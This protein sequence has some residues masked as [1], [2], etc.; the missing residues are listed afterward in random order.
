MTKINEVNKNIIKGL[1]KAEVLNRIKDGKVNILPKAPSRTIG[2]IVRANLFTSYNALNAILAIIVFMAGS[3]KNAVFAGVI[4]TNTIIGMFQ[5]IRAKGILERLSVLNEK[6]VDVIREGEINNINV[7]E[8]VLDDIIVLKAG[9]Q[10][11]VDCELLSHNE[12]E[13]DESL[14]TGEPDSILKIENDKLLSGSFVSAGNAYA[15]VI[16]VGENTYA[17]KLAEEA[18]KFKLI[19]SELQISINKIFR[20]IMWLAIPIGSLLI[21]TQL[22]HVKKSWQDAVLGSV[23]GIVGMVPEGLVLLTSATFVVAVIRLSKWDTLI[24]ELPA[25][26]V[27]ARVDVLCLDKTGTITK[28][29]LKVT[30]VQCLNNEDIKHIDKIIGA[31]VHSFKNGNATEKALLERYESN[32]NLKIKNKIP[33]SSKRK[34]SAVEFE[35]EGAFILGAPEMILKDEYKHIKNKIEKAAKEGKR[36]LLL[37]KYEGENFNENLKGSVKEIALIFIEDIIRENAEE[38]IDYFNKEQVNLKI[39]SG[40]NP[41]TV[42]SIAKKVGIKNAENYIDARELPE[43]EEELK[44][45]VDKISVFGRVSPHQKKSIVK[46]L[47]SNGHT[48]AMTG[49][50]VNDVLALKE[51]DCGIAMASGSEA[52]KA[53]AQLVLLNSDFAAIPQVVLEGRRLINNLEKVS[54]LFLS[55]TAYF[56]ILSIMFALLVKPFPIIPIQLTLIGSLSIGI[57]SF[58]LAIS[59]NEGVI[60]NDFLKRV[61]E[62]SIPNGILIGISTALM[63]LLGY[64]TGLSLEQ[65]RTLSLVTFGSLSLFILLKVSTPL[66]FYRVS[67]VVSMTILFV[68]A[69]L[70]PFTR[71]IFVIEYFGVEYIIPIIFIYSVAMILM[72]I[73]PKINRI[74]FKRVNLKKSMDRL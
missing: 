16:N 42:S 1:S 26:E 24:Q 30:E 67:I 48:V 37:A 29:D 65:C 14:I 4:I 15:K 20:I 28:G 35:E 6:T 52:T 68:L 22:F 69:F 46:A 51:S 19:N 74:I 39:I 32:P 57:P 54:E 7:E 70:I 66:N 18:K 23:S 33:F 71:R 72:L 61:L 63:F 38:I 56:I 27:L 49:D 31:I 50:G 60:K 43:D 11:L 73:I 2:Q 34:W 55:K 45:V 10:I 62:V 8:I 3:P 21:F 64:H 59:P 58:F 25:A 12:I 40:D 13:V 36:V 47:K 53:V 5:E 44:R 9:D 17:A 41:I